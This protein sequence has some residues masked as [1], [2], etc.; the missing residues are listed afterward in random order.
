MDALEEM[1]ENMELV[2]SEYR[3]VLRAASVKF[4]GRQKKFMKT[5]EEKRLHKLFN[6]QFRISVTNRL[7]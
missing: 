2:I 6:W 7:E 4:D 1:V 3:T 5:Q